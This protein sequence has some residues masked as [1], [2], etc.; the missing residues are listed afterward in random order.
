MP[1]PPSAAGPAV[2][3]TGQP[4]RRGGR[5]A[6]LVLGWLSLSAVLT[7]LAAHDR[8]APGLNYDEAMYGHFAKNFLMNHRDQVMAGSQVVSLFGRPFPLFLQGYLGALKSWMLLPGLALTGFSM[9]ALRMSIWVWAVV[10][11]LFYM[12]WVRRLLG[13]GAAVAAGF[14]LGLDPSFYFISICDWGP[15]VPSFVCRFAG[16]FC[17]VKWWQDGRGRDLS[18]AGLALGLGLFSK[19]DFAVV[20]AGSGI[21]LLA[22]Y[23]AGIWEALRR[24]PWQAVGGAAGFLLGAGL[25]TKNI[26]LILRGVLS[27]GI[28]SSME[29][30]EKAWTFRTMFDGSYFYRLIEHGGHFDRMFDAPA[31]FWA[32]FGLICAMAFVFLGLAVLRSRRLHTQE[33]FPAFLLVS[34][35]LVLLGVWLLPG[36]VR[37]HHWT[38]VYPLPHLLVV[39]AALRLW[40]QGLGP[41][42]PRGL[43]VLAVL[44]VAAVL[45]GHLIAIQATQRLIAETG[46]RGLWS[47]ALNAFAAEVRT[48]SDLTIVSY[49]WGFNEQLAFL[50]DGP[51]LVEPI[52]YELPAGRFT[53]PTSPDVIHLVHPP[54][55]QVFPLSG[56]LLRRVH[57][58]DPKKVSVRAYND[59]TG[60]TVF[61]AIRFLGG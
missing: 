32:P 23:R 29:P 61:Y 25:V 43:R 37:I 58:T 53:V 6:I 54:D 41:V 24:K 52:W 3:T 16:F 36:A 30:F 4:P 21:A 8:A 5:T 40:R 33:R 13:A 47:S 49:D 50:T 38:L 2:A 39:T 45:G 7:F 56:A 17:A 1:T 9:A 20:L 42:S 11:L 31:P 28:G 55:E 27:G 12:L 57:A 46:G 44:A 48:R 22:V 19:V 59:R 26:A 34:T 10:G 18:L 15:V 14:V 35:V 51:R 60:R